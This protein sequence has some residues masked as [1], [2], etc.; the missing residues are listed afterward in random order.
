MS[1]YKID[2]ND[3]RDLNANSSWAFLE[4]QNSQERNMSGFRLRIVF[5][6]SLAAVLPALVNAQTSADG[7]TPPSTQV[8]NPASPD[9]DLR[10]QVDRLERLVREQQK[11]I[12]ALEAGRPTTGSLPAPANAAPAAVGQSEASISSPAS[13]A[14]AP[15]NQPPAQIV[16]AGSSDQRIRNLERQIKGL[17]PI[18]FSGD[19]R[20]R[21]E[22]FFGGPADGSLDRMRGRVRA[23]VHAVGDPGSQFRT[24]I[25]LATGDINDP[26]STNQ[27]LTGFYTRKTVALDQ[28]FV[29]YAPTAF[30]PL[31]LTAGKFRYPWYNTELT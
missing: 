12:D 23:R 8:A 6:L 9:A 17:G 7:S 16:E 18:S 2:I 24:G 14:A 1:I 3:F 27:N 25:T 21:G 28:A 13:P 29:E 10:S 19:V 31:T 5:S 15:Q 20:L 30:K 26:V 4:S 11:R 22:P